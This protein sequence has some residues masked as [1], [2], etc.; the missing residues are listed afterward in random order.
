MGDRFSFP[1][2]LLVGLF[3]SGLVISNI[4]AVKPIAFGPFILPAAVV[5]FPVTYIIGDVVTEVYGYRA[6][7]RMIWT[8]FAGNLLAVL[9]A[10]LGGWLPPPVLERAGGLWRDLGLCPAAVA[11]LP[12]RLPGG[13][14]CQRGSPGEDE[15]PHPRAVDAAAVLGQHCGGGDP[16]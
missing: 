16:G 2:M 7:R 13:G 1:L 4:I 14:I 9:A 8:G 12:H 3:V 6:T 15:G 5:V 11:G 10:A